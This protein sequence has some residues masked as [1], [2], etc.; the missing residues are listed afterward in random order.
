VTPEQDL[1]SFVAG[2]SAFVDMGHAD[3]VRLFAWLQHYLFKRERFSTKDI[4]WC[5]DKLSYEPSNTSQYLKNMEGNELLKDSKGYRCEGKFRAEY[6]ARYAEHQITLS[7]RHLVKDLINVLP[8]LGEKDI[9]QEVLTCLKY[10]AG[11]AAII[12]VWNIAFYHLC[13]FILKY[14]LKEFNDRLPIRYPGKWKAA[15]MPLVK[16]Y[17]DFGD[18]MSEREVVEVASSAGIINGSMHKVYLA[19]LDERNSAAHPST[20]HVTQIQA[21]GFIDNLLHNTVLLLKI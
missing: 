7:V 6:D 4:N 11:R 14:H 16:K 15:N 19:K 2:V 10:D 17:D 9:F 18:E 1:Q 5:Y 8:E 13:Q 3:K 20:N 21:E 12:M